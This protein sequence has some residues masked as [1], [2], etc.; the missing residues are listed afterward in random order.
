MMRPLLL[1]TLGLLACASVAAAQAPSPT[2]RTSPYDRLAS[3]HQKIALALFSAQTTPAD[4]AATPPLTLAQISS[5]RLDG[6]DWGRIFKD[7]KERG[8]IVDK[9]LARVMIRHERA[10]TPAPAFATPPD[11]TN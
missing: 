10:G 2:L 7:M 1:A 6:Q 8:L 5:R 9:N 3:G 11:A 4:G